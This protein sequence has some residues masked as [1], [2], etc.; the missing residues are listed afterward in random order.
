MVRSRSLISLLPLIALC[1]TTLCLAQQPDTQA[2]GATPDARY[3][4]DVWLTVQPHLPDPQ[5]ASADTLMTAGDVLRARRFPEEAVKYYTYALQRGGDKVTLLNRI[6]VTDLDLNQPELARLYF[7]QATMIKKKYSQAWNNLGATESIVG[8]FPAAIVDYSK[9]VKLNRNNALFHANL[10]AA[11]FAIKDYESGRHEF[12]TAIK[13]DADVFHQG[14]AG[15]TM[16]HVLTTDDRG[17]FAFEMARL[18][19][20]HRDEEE[21]LHWLSVAAE[22]NFKIGDFMGGA[23]EL[24]VYAKDPRVLVILRNQR[25]LQSRKLAT[26]LP[27]PELPAPAPAKTRD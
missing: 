6:G 9:A 20:G 22:A 14:A 26:A 18:A 16:V 11:Y 10:G 5:T 13:L 25:T 2:Q 17:R 4:T 8:N 7:R 15:G 24:S 1:V 19:A 23:K 21:M 27:I 12:D 3:L